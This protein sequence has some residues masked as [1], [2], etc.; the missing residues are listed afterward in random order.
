MTVA[1]I[2][3]DSHIALIAILV[4]YMS[5]PSK[6]LAYRFIAGFQIIGKLELSGVLYRSVEYVATSLEE[7]KVYSRKLIVVLDRCAFP[8][9]VTNLKKLSLEAISSG[10]QLMTREQLRPR[11][12]TNDFSLVPSLIVEQSSGNKIMISYAS[13][14]GQNDQT[15]PSEAIRLCDATSPSLVAKYMYQTAAAAGVFLAKEIITLESG[16]DALRRQLT[17]A[18]LGKLKASYNAICSDKSR[19]KVSANLYFEEESDVNNTTN[20]GVHEYSA[21][22]HSFCV[23]LAMVRSQSIFRD[24][25]PRGSDTTKFVECPLDI[26]LRYH[27]RATVVARSLPYKVSVTWL[28]ERN[29]AERAIWVEKHWQTQHSFSII[30]NMKC[31]IMR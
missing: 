23:G 27:H 12:G 25:E 24:R 10:R 5:W 13:E 20:T 29:I 30:V 2:A 14:R 31:S 19:R 1:L 17:V 3:S 15:N 28:Q 6:D 7:P 18:D 9:D 16:I 4:Y 21:S 22:L 11:F 26:L 8:A